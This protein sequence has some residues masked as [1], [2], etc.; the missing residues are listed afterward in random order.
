MMKTVCAS[1]YQNI[2]ENYE[3]F[4]DV[5][6]L[7]SPQQSAP[8]TR[9]V[10]EEAKATNW[11]QNQLS[12]PDQL[13]FPRN[14]GELQSAIRTALANNAGPVVFRGSMHSWSPITAQSKGTAINVSRMIEK[15]VVDAEAQT[16]TVSGAMLLKDVYEALD[17]KGLTLASKPTILDVTAAGA[18]AT[19]THGASRTSGMLADQV[20]S[21][22]MVDGQGRLIKVNEE[23]SYELNSDGT[24]GLQIMSGPGPL[25]AMK[26]HRGVLGAVVEVTFACVPAFDLEFVQA[27]Q[28]QAEAFGPGYEGIQRFLNENEHGDFFWFVPDE[29]LLM[30]KANRTD[31]PRKPRNP[32]AA[33]ILDDLIRSRLLT[34]TMKLLH[35]FPSLGRAVGWIGAHTFFG[36]TIIRDRSDKVSSY[37]PGHASSESEFQAM[38][39]GVPYGRCAEALAIVERETKDFSM[40]IPMYFRRVGEKLYFEFL[41]LRN[42]PNG[43]E[44]AKRLEA[45][46][47]D[48]F[49]AGAMPHE[50]KLYFQ[51]PWNRVP[52]AD[53]E[54]FMA[55]KEEMDPNGIFLNQYMKKYFEGQSDLTDSTGTNP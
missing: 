18:L 6:S 10:G 26:L 31:L 19:G 44:T 36:E 33:L 51:N 21:V 3:S 42:Y 15:P 4:S 38:E 49:G 46:L 24:L 7:P 9:I 14:V 12:S 13:L 53:K 27:P 8:L 28:D 35:T 25:K 16:A 20:V 23:G 5:D 45:A 39:Y 41:W 32:I 29:K 2:N 48:A 17:A 47:I 54:N 11:A 52:D 50:G 43:E 55:M 1:S 40:P 30:R 37:L 34:L 22:K